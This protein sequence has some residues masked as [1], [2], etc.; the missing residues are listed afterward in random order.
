MP[1]NIE[2]SSKKRDINV[3]QA[4]NHIKDFKSDLIDIKGDIEKYARKADITPSVP[5]I[6]GQQQRHSN[7]ETETLTE[8]LLQ[9]SAH[10]SSVMDHLISEM[11]THFDPNTVIMM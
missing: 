3:F 1:F 4:Y 10:S 7:V 11:N 9:K 8:G 6:I 5:R 2:A